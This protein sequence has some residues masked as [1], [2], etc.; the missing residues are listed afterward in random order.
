MA[1][2]EVAMKSACSSLSMTQGPAMRNSSG[3][4]MVTFCTE[5]GMGEL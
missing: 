4:P 2:M 1:A 5:K 3:P